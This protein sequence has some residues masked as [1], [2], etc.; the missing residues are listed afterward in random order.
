MPE[1]SREPP[2]QHPVP[3][4]LKRFIWDIQ[5]MIELEASEREILFVGR[6]LMR[7]L[8]EGDG[9]LPQ[10]YAKPNRGCCQQFQ[11]YRDD[12]E[13]FTVVSTVF[14]SGQTSPIVRDQVWEITGVLR[15]TFECSSFGVSVDGRPEPKGAARLLTAGMVDTKPTSG[16][17]ATRI[18]NVP[19]G[20]GVL[21]HVYGGE[22]SQLTRRTF[23]SNGEV[24]E[25]PAAYAND[26]HAPPYDIHSIQTRIVD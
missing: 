8:V 26:E 17:V 20:T 3:D 10:P 7:R 9:W 21:V 25:A 18:R 6:D 15:G 16:D 13:R 4:A 23:A 19:N 14:A 24:S 1:P 12:L 2:E 11:L 5:S 22:I